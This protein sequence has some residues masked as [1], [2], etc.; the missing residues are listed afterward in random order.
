MKGAEAGI[1]AF[2]A[3]SELADGE[4]LNWPSLW[5]TVSL[6]SQTKALN[7]DRLCS[8]SLWLAPWSEKAEAAACFRST[9]LGVRLRFKSQTHHH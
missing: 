2:V 9:S 8:D 3:A 5:A 4:L 1:A 7:G 6:T